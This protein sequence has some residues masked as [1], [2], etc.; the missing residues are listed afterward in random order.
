MK[1]V[2][3]LIAYWE[4]RGGN[5]NRRHFLCLQCGLVGIGKTDLAYPEGWR[6]PDLCYKCTPL[7]GALWPLIAFGVSLIVITTWLWKGF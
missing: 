3:P 1:P 7:R 5:D 4:P 2:D 6:R